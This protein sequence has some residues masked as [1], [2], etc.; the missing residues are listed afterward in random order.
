MSNWEIGICFW[1]S[2]SLC[3]WILA[4]K[5]ICCRTDALHCESLLIVL[6]CLYLADGE[7]STKARYGNRRRAA[8]GFSGSWNS[9]WAY[10]DSQMHNWLWHCLREIEEYSHFYIVLF[11]IS[12]SSQEPYFQGSLF[13]NTEEESIIYS[14]SL[15][16]LP[17]C[18]ILFDHP[19]A[20]VSSMLLRYEKSQS[21]EL[22]LGWQFWY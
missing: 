3:P 15:P 16:F 13:K 2:E 9:V 7:E 12:V 19:L 11:Y 17:F 6:I 14:L 21:I 10:W 1:P 4:W 20:F 18:H 22:V 5:L 8:P